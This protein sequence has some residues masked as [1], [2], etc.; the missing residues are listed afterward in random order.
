M[1]KL[2]GDHIPLTANGKPA[3]RDIVQFVPFKKFTAQQNPVFHLTREVLAEVPIQVV[4]YMREHGYEPKAPVFAQS[5]SIPSSPGQYSHQ[6]S[7][8]SDTGNQPLY[9]DVYA[10]G[11]LPA[12]PAHLA[13]QG[14]GSL[15][16]Y[17]VPQLSTSSEGFTDLPPQPHLNSTSYA[18][19]PP[20]NTPSS[21]Y[22]SVTPGLPP[23]PQSYAYGPPSVTHGQGDAPYFDPLQAN[24]RP[25][26]RPDN[27]PQ[28]T[29]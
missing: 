18:S 28:P 1:E 21:Y 11:T 16:Q 14:S 6:S 13:G 15:H 7:Y 20:E 9:P 22:P 12:P 8:L 2:D 17:A 3:R 25:T 29:A 26:S 5:Y 27:L 4:S 10:T 19:A 24:P 23:R